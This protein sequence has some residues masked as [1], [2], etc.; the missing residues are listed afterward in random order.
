MNNI[1]SYN[2][3]IRHIKP[4][5][6]RLKDYNYKPIDALYIMDKTIDYYVKNEE[7]PVFNSKKHMK[8]LYQLRKEYLDNATID[9]IKTLKTIKNSNDFEKDFIK[10]TDYLNK[11]DINLFNL[12]NNNSIFSIDD[13]ITVLSNKSDEEIDIK[14]CFRTFDEYYSAP[15]VYKLKRENFKTVNCCN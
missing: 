13:I 5:I 11:R 12:F 10:Y 3:F 4:E 8:N 1:K 14:S 6:K 2:N 9:I 15:K 7:Y